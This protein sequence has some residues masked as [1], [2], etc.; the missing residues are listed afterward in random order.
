MP[1]Y[2]LFQDEAFTPEVVAVLG[3]VFEDVLRELG[4]VDRADP[5]TETVAKKL[6]ELAASATLRV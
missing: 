3:E 2:R 6:I 4:L 1:I 5:L